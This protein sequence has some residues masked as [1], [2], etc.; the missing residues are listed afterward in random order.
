MSCYKR[1]VYRDYVYYVCTYH[2]ENK[3]KLFIIES[4]NFRK[5]VKPYIINKVITNFNSIAELIAKNNLEK[6]KLKRVKYANDVRR[7]LREENLYLVDSNTK[8]TTREGTQTKKLPKKSNINPK[9]VPKAIRYTPS[10][11]RFCIDF[12]YNGKK[13]YYPLVSSSK[14]SLEGK[15]EGA[16]MKL[17]EFAEKHPEIASEKHLIENYSK[18]NIQSMK[19]YNNIIILSDFDCINDN[20]IK[21][22]KR[23]VVKVRMN[24]LS[25]TDKNIL[26]NMKNI[27][28]GSR[29][30]CNTILPENCEKKISDLPMYCTYI[31][32]KNNKG[33]YFRIRGHPKQEKGK[34]LCTSTKI[35][36]STNDKFKQ[37]LNILHDIDPNNY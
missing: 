25:K 21:I 32:S 8:S 36:V 13:Y 35:N 28:T 1:I 29:R 22:P 26:N 24:H 6:N 31:P 14:L 11:K 3:D 34:T 23:K 18:E 19:D 4:D 33:D 15:F 17:I 2:T 10:T 27:E 7:D 37:L 9:E 16:K 20:L 5:Y 12:N 30:R